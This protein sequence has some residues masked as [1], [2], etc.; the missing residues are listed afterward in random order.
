MMNV[1]R[2]VGLCLRFRC[3]NVAIPNPLVHKLLPGRGIVL[4]VM[5][6]YKQCICGAANWEIGLNVYD[7]R[8]HKVLLSTQKLAGF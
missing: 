3:R 2:L 6:K 7:W 4:R 1:E 8:L 5:V